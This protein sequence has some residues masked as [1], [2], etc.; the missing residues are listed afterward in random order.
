MADFFVS[1]EA[2]ADLDQIHAYIFE[3]NPEEAD[4]VLE[5]ALATF[6]TLAMTPGMGR[7]R[8]F[9]NSALIGLRSFRVHGFRNYLIFYRSGRGGVEIVRVLHAA[10]DLDALFR[11]D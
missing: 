9:T 6:V 8:T 5:A 4:R 3:A 11:D 1:P 10:R 7:P 2:R